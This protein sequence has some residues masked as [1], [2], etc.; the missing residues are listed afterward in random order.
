MWLARH[1]DVIMPA[2]S[3]ST[4][5]GLP[6]L[7]G[8]DR[9]R[10][11]ALAE[12]HADCVWMGRGGTGAARTLAFFEREAPIELWGFSDGTALIGQWCKRGWSCWSAPPLT[13][14]PRLDAPSLE[15]LTLAL[16]GEVP[17]FE[18]LTTIVPGYTAGPLAGGN[19]AVLCSLV[20]TPHMP[21]L[22]DAIVVLEDVGE[23]AYR[24]DRM[25]HQL[26]FSGAFEGVAG[27]AL[28]AFTGIAEAEGVLVRQC[29]EAFFGALG[30]PCVAGLPF[31]HGAANAALPMG[32]PFVLHDGRLARL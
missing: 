2:E 5:A 22:H 31:G 14:I 27:V 30:L 11:R 12:A 32:V 17:A 7:A 8:D 26:L 13:Q 18:G 24:V 21:R 1:L 9:C 23:V 6:W 16:Q 20:G 10:A 15:R 3:P 28:G 29:L 4:A 19:L 25:L